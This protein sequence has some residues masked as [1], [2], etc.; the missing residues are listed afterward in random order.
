MGS[1]LGCHAIKLH[2]KEKKNANGKEMQENPYNFSN[3]LLS[4]T[5]TTVE[6]YTQHKM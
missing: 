5:Q 6:N 3:L 2:S 1:I 4:T